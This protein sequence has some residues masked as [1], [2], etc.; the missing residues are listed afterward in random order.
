M[1]KLEIQDWHVGT[2][3]EK[4]KKLKEKREKKQ[5]KRNMESK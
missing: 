2:R 1:K 3:K 5:R 4:N